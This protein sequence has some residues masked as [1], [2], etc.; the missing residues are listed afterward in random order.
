MLSLITCYF[1][2]DFLAHCLMF[3][4]IF[5][6]PPCN[7]LLGTVNLEACWGDINEKKKEIIVF[8][9]QKI[10]PFSQVWAKTP[11]SLGSL[12]S[13]CHLKEHLTSILFP[14]LFFFSLNLQLPGITLHIFT[15]LLID[16]LLH[17]GGVKP[18]LHEGRNF[19]CCIPRAKSFLAHRKLS[20]SIC[21]MDE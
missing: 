9:V 6:F 8:V 1:R 16:S 14:V 4:I 19:I 13:L 15:H 2:H 5:S 21:K 18:K 3:L 11:P 12:P 7:H 10:M 20:M 17:E